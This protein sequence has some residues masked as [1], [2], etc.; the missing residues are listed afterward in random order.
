MIE[1]TTIIGFA[2]ILMIL[3]II[4]IVMGMYYMNKDVEYKQLLTQDDIKKFV[5]DIKDEIACERYTWTEIH[6]I[7]DE[8]AEERF[9]IKIKT[10]RVELREK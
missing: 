8:K 2:L 7:I 9:G 3:G 6:D 10:I 1:P 4:C 5:N